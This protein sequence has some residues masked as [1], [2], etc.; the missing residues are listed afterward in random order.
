MIT[1]VEIDPR[2]LRQTAVAPGREIEQAAERWDGAGGQA[3]ELLDFLAGGEAEAFDAGFLA[4]LLARQAAVG[5][6]HNQHKLLVRFANQRFRPASERSSANRRRLFARKDRSV[7]EDAELDP[8]ALQEAAQAIKDCQSHKAFLG[9]GLHQ[10]G[11]R[12]TG[13]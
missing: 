7:L 6:Q 4:D 2:L 3:G 13:I 1:S 5:R 10:V 8:F 9:R 12:Q 11:Q